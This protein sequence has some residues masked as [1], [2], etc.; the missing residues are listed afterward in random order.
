MY[1]YIYMYI[2]VYIYKYITIQHSSA[3][4]FKE[5]ALA[6]LGAEAHFLRLL[7]QHLHTG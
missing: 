7:L 3:V 5:T 4:H 1:I 2:Y 6:L